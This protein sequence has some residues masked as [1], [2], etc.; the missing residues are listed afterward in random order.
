MSRHRDVG[1]DAE[2][3]RSKKRGLSDATC[4]R[5]C[6]GTGKEV[7][8]QSGV[9]ISFATLMTLTEYAPVSTD[10]S[11]LHSGRSVRKKNS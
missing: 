9:L 2:I 4:L 1:L 6:F 10:E 11:D 7:V 8:A 5:E 3:L